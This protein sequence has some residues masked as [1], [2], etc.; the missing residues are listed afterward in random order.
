VSH[1]MAIPARPETVSPPDQAAAFTLRFPRRDLAH[2]RGLDPL[3]LDGF[4]AQAPVR[5]RHTHDVMTTLRL[6]VRRGHRHGVDSPGTAL[7]MLRDVDPLLCRLQRHI[8]DLWRYDGLEPLLVEC[9]RVAEHPP[10]GGNDTYGDH[11]PQDERARLFTGTVEERALYRGLALGE[12]RLDDLLDE[13]AVIATA[14]L[15]R[16]GPAAAADR[17]TG[18]WQPMID[19][20]RLM[21]KARVAPVM[22]VDIAPWVSNVLTIDGQDY[23]GPTAAQLPVVLV[24]WLLWGCDV[25]D[26]RYVEYFLYYFAEQPWR[27][28]WLVEQVLACTEGRSLVTRWEQ[29]ADRIAPRHRAAARRTRA[30]L[31]ALLTRMIGF[32]VSHLRF[33]KPSLPEREAGDRSWGS[34]QFDPEMLDRLLGHTE[35]AQARLRAVSV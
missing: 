21:R 26:P 25:D 13:L 3:G 7:A 10:R 2:V 22:A 16:P 4:Y 35:R 18:L 20:A 5:L 34:G 24:D 17:L 1:A 33:A 29:D 8:P 14:P 11:N 28:R 30:G 15:G 9:G 12:S 27:R 31:D 23:R 19:A 32:R 6:A